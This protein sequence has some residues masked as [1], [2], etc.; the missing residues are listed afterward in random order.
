MVDI[1]GDVL[2]NAGGRE[3]LGLADGVLDGEGVGGAVA[4]MPGLEMPMRG[5]PPTSPESIIFLK[6][7]R[8]PETSTAASLV[9]RFFL[10]MALSCFAMKP[11][12]PSMV[13]RKMLP[14]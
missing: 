6:S 8:P 11:P 3:A 2:N 12:V 5:V 13:L 1:F 10:N 4:L 14:E 7:R 9:S